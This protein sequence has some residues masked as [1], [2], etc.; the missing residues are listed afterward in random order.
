VGGLDSRWLVIAP[1]KRVDVEETRKL[2]SV[3]DELGR[4][5]WQCMYRLTL[6]EE[7]EPLLEAFLYLAPLQWLAYHW[8][9][10]LG[11]DPDNPAARDIIL[12]AIL[13]VGRK[14]LA[15]RELGPK[16]VQR[17]HC[18]WGSLAAEAGYPALGWPSETQAAFRRPCCGSSGGGQQPP[19]HRLTIIRWT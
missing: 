7:P 18:I 13:P 19:A 5:G 14:E 15:S 10:E 16:R 4:A 17:S 8:A 2:V 1:L 9:V 6:P 3:A 12:T 11:L